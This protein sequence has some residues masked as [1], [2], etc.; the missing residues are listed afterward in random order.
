MHK[1]KNVQLLPTAISITFGLAITASLIVNLSILRA[2]HNGVIWWPY[3]AGGVVT[4]W[5][6]YML[7]MCVRTLKAK[8]LLA[9]LTLLTIAVPYSLLIEYLTGTSG[10]VRALYVPLSI[11]VVIAVLLVWWVVRKRIGTWPVAATV[12]GLSAV[13]TFIVNQLVNVYIASLPGGHTQD[14][15]EVFINLVAV[16]LLTFAVAAY[17]I[18]IIKKHNPKG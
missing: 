4:V 12:L 9:G 5:I 2:A 10:W 15:I 14:G 17:A 3:V 1:Q 18:G 11:I 16:A 6:P 8:L 13:V 7:T